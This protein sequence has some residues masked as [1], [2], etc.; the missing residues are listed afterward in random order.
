MVVLGRRGGTLLGQ[1][2][3]LIS[4]IV[5][6]VR[7]QNFR[8]NIAVLMG[9][10]TCRYG[11]KV[12]RNLGGSFR[13][14]TTK[15]GG[16]QNETCAEANPSH[17]TGRRF[18]IKLSCSQGHFLSGCLQGFSIR[19]VRIRQPAQHAAVPRS[20]CACPAA[21][22]EPFAALRVLNV[23]TLA[24]ERLCELLPQGRRLGGQMRSWRALVGRGT[25]RL[26]PCTA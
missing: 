4:F 26:P 5:R 10:S 19:T 24:H 9:P 17:G 20:R 12:S 8:R 21:S 15:F 2:F 6:R 16:I 18:V 14:N 1:V 25:P 13:N 7:P 23:R 11:S 3:N 22:R